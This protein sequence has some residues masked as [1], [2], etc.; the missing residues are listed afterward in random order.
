MATYTP[1]SGAC[2]L[3]ACIS[4]I[5]SVG[6]IFEL[7]SGTPEWGT[8][9]T[10]LILASSIPLTIGLFYIAVRSSNAANK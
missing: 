7:S 3:G 10:S 2:L 9:T 4:A 6:S 1:L 5:A 8:M